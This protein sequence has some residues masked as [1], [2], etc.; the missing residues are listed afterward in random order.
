MSENSCIAPGFRASGVACGLKAGGKKDIALVVS[1][2]PATAAGV[3][4][5]NVVCGAPVKVSRLHIADGRARAVVAN[6]GNSNVCTGERGEKDALAMCERAA[7]G[8]G[9]AAADVLVASTG[10]IGRFLPMDRVLPGIDKAVAALSEDG[11]NAASEAV[12]TTDLVPKRARRRFAHGGCE[13]TVAGFCK[14]SGMIAPKLATMLAFLTTD[15]SIAVEHL[16]G[17]LRAAVDVS[18]NRVTVDGDTSTSDTVVILANGQAGAPTIEPGTPGMAAFAEALTNVCADLSRAIAAD[19]EGATK[20]FTVAIEGAA[21]AAEADRAAR[22]VAESPLVKTAVFGGDP[23]WGRIAAAIGRSG[24][25]FEEKRLRVW[26]GRS[27]AVRERDADRV[28]P[29]GGRAA[30]PAEDAHDPRRPGRR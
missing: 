19:G 13:V 9:V 24:A 29:E 20:F 17:A 18:F 23:N 15:A 2:S 16:Q 27:A 8:I 3:F 26:V 4:T 28:R 30:L 14:G 10:V 6:A 5:S 7:S 21:S 11:G 22:T 25:S 1:D 12:M